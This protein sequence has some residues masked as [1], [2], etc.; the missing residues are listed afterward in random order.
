ML[1]G[2]QILLDSTRQTHGMRIEPTSQQT[3]RL[4]APRSGNA[5]VPVDWFEGSPEELP[6]RPDVSAVPPPRLLEL[7][8]SSEQACAVWDR[9]RAG[10]HPRESLELYAISRDAEQAMRDA[11]FVVSRDPD[12]LGYM[13]ELL[14]ATG[15]SREAR[16]ALA[17]SGGKRSETL[18]EALRIAGSFHQ[19]R[20]L[21]QRL[22]SRPAE[23][24]RQ[25]LAGLD[26]L[27]APLRVRFLAEQL[28]R[29]LPPETLGQFRQLVGPL[30]RLTWTGGEGWRRESG[31]WTY[32]GGGGALESSPMEL[33]AAQCK[34]S[35]S[36]NCNLAD[37]SSMSLEVRCV[38]GEWK[39]ISFVQGEGELVREPDL[40]EW[41]GRKVQFRLRPSA[42]RLRLPAHYVLG[43]VK[44]SER[45][46]GPAQVLQGGRDWNALPVPGYL[47]VVSKPLDLDPANP[48]EMQLSLVMTGQDMVLEVEGS[49]LTRELLR[50]AAAYQPRLE[51][52][53]LDLGAFRGERVSFRFRATAP[54]TLNLMNT[55][56]RARPAA[57]AGATQTT[58]YE[59][60]GLSWDDAGRLLNLV[61]RE[62]DAVLAEVARLIPLLGSLETACQVREQLPSDTR[63]GDLEDRAL[64]CAALLEQGPERLGWLRS[65]VEPGERWLPSARLL[66]QRT[67]EEW[68]TLRRRVRAEGSELELDACLEFVAEEGEEAWNTAAPPLRDEP[69]SQ[70]LQAYRELAANSKQAQ[71]LFATLGDAL[72][73]EDDFRETMRAGAA[74]AGVAG[75]RLDC[76]TLR[77]IVE[78]RG[79]Q[80]LLAVLQSLSQALL[81]RPD[82]TLEQAALALT[83][84]GVQER[85]DRVI[86]AGVSL[87]R[88]SR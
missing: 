4:T 72:G 78:S 54:A 67:A 56:I 75:P 85:E 27:P 59:P 33:P 28:E 68:R 24:A 49:S 3:L 50:F 47:E 29:P 62:G 80:P 55:V 57:P 65:E 81:L 9:L 10:P 48:S 39:S 19:A 34:L 20:P 52:Q 42:P 23:E 2:F 79:A 63:P 43:A 31:S 37:Q 66:T 6:A 36:S 71:S 32:R 70:R 61:Y 51:E 22:A 25:R 14:K 11:A 7:G 41:E 84:G 13:A 53:S 44:L 58:L 1:T 60:G 73:P 45:P 35:W 64:A 38:G 21:W 88:R 86:I 5:T 18:L 83:Q 82:Q 76:S 16:L 77:R 15:S 17:A 87:R 40:R 46:A 8:L 69:L 30:Y 26:D 12:A 74:F